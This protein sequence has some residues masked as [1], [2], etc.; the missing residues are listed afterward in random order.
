MGSGGSTTYRPFVH[1][2]GGTGG[3]VMPGSAR[4]PKNGV[5]NVFSYVARTSGSSAREL[6]IGGNLSTTAWENANGKPM[7]DSIRQTN[8][9][10][11][12]GGPNESG[13]NF[14]EPRADVALGFSATAS[15]NTYW[16]GQYGSPRPSFT[17]NSSGLGVYTDM[18]HF[19]SSGT[20]VNL[21][22][23]FNAHNIGYWTPVSLGSLDFIRLPIGGGGGGGWGASGGDT[24][25]WNVHTSGIAYGGA[26]GPAVK[27]NGNAVTWTGGQ[28][29]DRVFGAVS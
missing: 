22:S 10:P 3:R 24:Y 16:A 21:D 19:N 25:G 29:T 12:G 4:L 17:I 18:S 13:M 23:R 1:V 27:T 6:S 9:S 26:G 28:G 2:G 8:I 7:G 14:I 20:F 11:I 5:K 15:S